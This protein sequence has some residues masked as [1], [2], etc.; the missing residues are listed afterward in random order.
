MMGIGEFH[1]LPG[2]EIDGGC[3]DRASARIADAVKTLIVAYNKDNIRRLCMKTD[4]RE[5]C[6]KQQ[7]I[8]H[9]AKLV[10][11]TSN[12]RRRINLSLIAD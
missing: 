5:E 8:F 12:Y 10:A 6:K 1:S 9:D 3:I 11:K 7:G 2:Q 4:N